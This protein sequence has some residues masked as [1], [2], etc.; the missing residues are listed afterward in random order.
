M[1]LKKIPKKCTNRKKEKASDKEPVSI[2]VVRACRTKMFLSEDIESF[3]STGTHTNE[4]SK[5]A[6][7]RVRK[8][9]TSSTGPRKTEI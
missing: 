9:G 3:S 7:K 6:S 8:V 5:S 2:K 1:S 4:D